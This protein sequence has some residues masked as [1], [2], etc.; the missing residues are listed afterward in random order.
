VRARLNGNSLII[1]DFNVVAARHFFPDVKIGAERR[2]GECSELA[3]S[4]SARRD[5]VLLTVK[6]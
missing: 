6:Y 3:S 5:F 2:R 1:R 4:D